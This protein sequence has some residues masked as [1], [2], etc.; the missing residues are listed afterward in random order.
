[1][2][3]KESGMEGTNFIFWNWTVAVYLFVAGISAGA[4]AISAL[5]HF[6]GEGKYHNV[7]R[8]GAYIAPFPLLFGLLCLIYDLE[9]PRLFWKLMVTLQV[10]SIM[11]L[12]AWLLSIFSLLSFAYFYLW[13]P[14]RFDTVELLR[15]LPERWDK[16]AIIRW[17]KTSPLLEK[18]HRKNLNAFRGWIAM[19]GIPVALLVGIYTGVLLG[20]LVARP[21]WNNPMLPMLFLVSALKAGTASICLVG[22]VSTGIG[23][24]SREQIETNK[25]II[26]SIDFF[27][28]ILSIIAILLF[29]FGLYSA[30]GSS[31]EAAGLI[32]GGEY[33]FLF[34][35]MAVAVGVLLP[36]S[37]ELYELI[38][39]FIGHA[40][41]RAHN[42]WISGV[43]TL[44]V[45]A[46][47]FIL[48]YVVVYAGQT[49]KL[50]TM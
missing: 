21:F 44:S 42:P 37:L 18:V 30:P 36:L 45:L 38:P 24:M 22:C 39:H 17:L 33:T 46:G 9:R 1:M 20:A 26:H 48:R 15:R 14:D 2:V 5:A 29:V 8:I 13:L 41:M 19:A 34:W 31:A 27:L 16:W 49:A 25:F 28:M 50:V 32:M 6:I 43:T 11:S 23:W 47:G 40:A 35:G 4:F 10:H 12:G 3:G 7:T